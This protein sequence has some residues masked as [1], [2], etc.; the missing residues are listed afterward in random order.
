M[1]VL[2]RKLTSVTVSALLSLVFVTALFYHNHVVCLGD[3]GTVQLEYVC[4]VDCHAEHQSCCQDERAPCFLA[5]ERCG[6]CADF[7][8]LT[9]IANVANSDNTG[10]LR[11]DD[12]RVLTECLEPPETSPSNEN[13]SPRRTLTLAVI[14]PPGPDILSSC[15]LIC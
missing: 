14:G 3:D 7:P 9:E 2:R 12:S 6:D 13:Q 5:D 15:I 11:A 10:H 1:A 8:L 4:E